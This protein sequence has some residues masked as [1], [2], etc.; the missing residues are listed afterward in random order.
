[1]ASSTPAARA[2]STNPATQRAKPC[3]SASSSGDTPAACAASAVTGAGCGVVDG[4]LAQ[5]VS[6]TAA[7]VA[8]CASG[9]AVGEEEKA[10]M[11]GFSPS[12]SIAV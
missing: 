3:C 10:G 12:G 5:A 7:S 2:D 4:G 6:A 11:R 8:R 1:M 9:G